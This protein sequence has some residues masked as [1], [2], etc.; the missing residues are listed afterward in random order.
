MTLLLTAETLI[1][2]ALALVISIATPGQTRLPRL[3]GGPQ[4]LAVIAVTAMFAAATGAAVSW[5]QIYTHS[6]PGDI[7]SQIVAIALIL[8]IVVEPIFAL[9]VALGLR[10]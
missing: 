7:P 3:P 10:S 2:T 5:A 8:T 6:Y 9:L 1:L 4:L